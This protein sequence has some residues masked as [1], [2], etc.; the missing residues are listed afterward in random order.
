MNDDSSLETLLM[1][2]F[3]Y[4]W[5]IGQPPSISLATLK[6]KLYPPDCYMYKRSD[7]FWFSVQP[8]LPFHII[9]RDI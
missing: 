5:F 2:I 1:F 3:V 4:L 6:N 7:L 9:A 8:N